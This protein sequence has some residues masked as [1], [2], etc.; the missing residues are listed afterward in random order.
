[1]DTA[2]ILINLGY[3]FMLA[4]LAVRDILWLR[5]LLFSAQVSLFSYG[6]FTDNTPVIFW[7]ALFFLIN[8]YQVIRLIR[9]RRPIDL[10]E[11]LVDLYENIF[12]SMRRR[13]FLYFWQM[14]NLHQVVHKKLIGRGE[15]QKDLLLIL[16]GELQV[17]NKGKLIASLTRGNFVAEMSFLTGEPATAD[18]FAVDEVSYISWNQN[19]LHSLEQL[20]PDLLIKIQNIL[21]KDLT[22]K[23]KKDLVVKD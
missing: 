9:Q 16:S 7:N 15:P 17:K 22:S 21:G 11:D 23:L 14:G 20:N 3:I 12:S 19:K 6:I 5:S 8:G 10:P 4:A 18:V 2:Q 1:M 13:E